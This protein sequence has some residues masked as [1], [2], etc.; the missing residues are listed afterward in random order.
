VKTRFTLPV[1]MRPKYSSESPRKATWQRDAGLAGR[2]LFLISQQ[3][4]EP[5]LQLFPHR[6]PTTLVIRDL[7]TGA[8]V[9]LEVLLKSD[10]SAG[11]TTARLTSSFNPNERESRLVEPT[12]L[13]SPSTSRILACIIDGWYS[14]IRAP[15]RSR[16]PY[17]VRLDGL[18]TG[19][20]FSFQASRL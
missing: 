6:S 18:V 4:P 11:S 2:I 19:D 9:A 1:E 8:Q 15:P 7:A 20:R 3:P 10:V 17:S 14:K 16:S 13:H 5:L 12:T